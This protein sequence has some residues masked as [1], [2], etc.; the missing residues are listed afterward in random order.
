MGKT[1]E[2]IKISL[3]VSLKGSPKGVLPT[4]FFE[5][6]IF[7]LKFAKTLHFTQK[8]ENW[9]FWVKSDVWAPEREKNHRESRVFYQE[10]HIL[11][12]VPT[13]D[14]LLSV[15]EISRHS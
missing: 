1:T 4:K 10:T 12:A 6:K 11:L 7:I 5:I 9:H 13:T 14:Y 8:I 2:D 15:G 3:T